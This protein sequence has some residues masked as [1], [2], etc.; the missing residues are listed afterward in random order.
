[1]LMI[2]DAGLAMIDSSLYS[3]DQPGRYESY[4][5]NG[6]QLRKAITIID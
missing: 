6:P 2:M 1:M 4:Q 5:G 3:F